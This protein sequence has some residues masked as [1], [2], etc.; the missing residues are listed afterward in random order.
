MMQDADGQVLP[1]HSVSAGL[2]Y[3]GVGAEHSY[4]K[5]TGRVEYVAATDDEALDAFRW[6]AEKEGIIPAFESAHAFAALRM[7]LVNKGERVLVNLSGR[8]DKD[9]ERASQLLNL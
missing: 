5:D 2:D 8:G 6:L 3:P 9:M 1:T 4:L 7:G